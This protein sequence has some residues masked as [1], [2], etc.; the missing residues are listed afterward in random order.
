MGRCRTSRRAERAIRAGTLISWARMVAVVALAWKAEARAPAARVRLNAIAAQT[1]QAPFAV[2]DPDGRWASG[3]C[4]QVGD[5]LLDD[6]VPAVAV[7]GL[8]HRQRCVGEHRVVA[9]AGEQLALA[10]RGVGV[11]GPGARSAGR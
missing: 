11:A 6:G 5:D 7:L 4:L 8:D 1:S 10:G 2:N 9:V 3:P